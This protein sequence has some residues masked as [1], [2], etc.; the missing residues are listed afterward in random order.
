MRE[1]IVSITTIKL[2]GEHIG[3]NRMWF[4]VRHGLFRSNAK[5]TI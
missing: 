5:S 1:L 4:G 2:L 3:E